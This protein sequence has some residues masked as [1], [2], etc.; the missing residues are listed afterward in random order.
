MEIE[1]QLHHNSLGLEDGFEILLE[2]DRLLF[3]I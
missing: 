2:K 3:Q 1:I